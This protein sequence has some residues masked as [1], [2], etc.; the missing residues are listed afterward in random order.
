M[1]GRRFE[2][3]DWIAMGVLNGWCTEPYCDTH[4]SGHLTPS[5]YDA[6]EAGEDWCVPVVRLW[7]PDHADAPPRPASLLWPQPELSRDWR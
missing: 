1:N 5:E 3:A 7:E 2:Q 6:F 4:D